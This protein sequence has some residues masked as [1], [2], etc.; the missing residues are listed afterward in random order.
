MINRFFQGIF[1]YKCTY[2]KFHP[3]TVGEVSKLCY[4]SIIYLSFTFLALALPKILAFQ[5]SLCYHIEYG[6]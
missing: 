5:D 3:P 2:S 6:N 4:E 1:F